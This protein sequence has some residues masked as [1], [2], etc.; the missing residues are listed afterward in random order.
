M[1]IH[2]TEEQISGIVTAFLKA[3]NG[4][5]GGFRVSLGID[6][7][8]STVWYGGPDGSAVGQRLT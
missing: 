6:N 3:T 1:S 2:L 7:T 5:R 8:P 4:E